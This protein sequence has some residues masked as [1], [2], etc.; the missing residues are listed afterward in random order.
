MVLSSKGDINY[1]LQDLI[2]LWFTSFIAK[3]IG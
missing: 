2:L 3:G 1:D